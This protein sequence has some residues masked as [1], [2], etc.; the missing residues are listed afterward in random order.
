HDVPV[1]AA[2]HDD[3]DLWCAHIVV[4]CCFLKRKRDSTTRMACRGML[5]LSKNSINFRAIYRASQ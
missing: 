4:P 1:T 3:G 5:L 2:A